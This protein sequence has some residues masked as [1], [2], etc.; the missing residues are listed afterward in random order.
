MQ[1]TCI[2]VIAMLT[3]AQ[4]MAA[5]HED[6]L[7]DVKFRDGL[8]IRL[9]DGGPVDVDGLALRGAVASQ[10]LAHLR[11]GG[12]TRTH[13]LGEEQLSALKRNGDQQSATPLPD[14]N[15]Y[16]RLRLPPGLSLAVAEAELRQLSEVESVHRVSLPLPPPAAPDLYTPTN[17]VWYQRYLDAAPD[18]VGIRGL[19]PADL[20]TEKICDVE[21]AWN[22]S[23][24][25]LPSGIPQVTPGASIPF[26]EPDLIFDTIQHGTSVLGIIGATAE[27][28]PTGIT[29]GAF[30][31]RLVTAGVHNGAMNVAQAITN[32]IGQGSTIIVVEQQFRNSLKGFVDYIPA[33]W[34]KPVHDAIRTAVA[35]GIVV[36]AVAGNGGANLDD[37][38][39]ETTEDLNK[40]FRG[41]GASGSILVGAGMSPYGG[42]VTRSPHA[43]S[44]YGSAIDVQGWGDSVVTL[45]WG[46]YYA[47]EGENLY[48]TFSADGTSA[49]APIVASAAAQLQARARAATGTALS[50]LIIKRLLKT[51]STP[52]AHGS[53]RPRNIGPLPNVA[54]AVSAISGGTRS[55]TLGDSIPYT[56]A[57]GR[58]TALNGTH[59][60]LNLSAGGH[61][62]FSLNYD[63]FVTSYPSVM[64]L[65]VQLV[66]DNVVVGTWL[67]QGSGRHAS[68]QVVALGPGAHTAWYQ[69]RSQLKSGPPTTGTIRGAPARF[70]AIPFAVNELREWQLTQD[71]IPYTGSTGA[72]TLVRDS[73]LEVDAPLGGL[74]GF[75]FAYS[76]FQ[77]P[78]PAAMRLEVRLM[79]DGV[80]QGRA[81]SSSNSAFTFGPTARLSP[82]THTVW[83]EVR[84]VLWSG[85]PATGTL[86]GT[87]GRVTARFISP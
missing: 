30:G 72:F 10:V 28:V 77:T 48:Y 31:A 47:A 66:V 40:P 68:A 37:A 17:F 13:A 39:Y 42:G 51:H 82:G 64:E 21:Y 44:T 18:G 43:Y 59:T 60:T 71:S 2:A 76:Y 16:F 56:G 19:A 8:S 35:N 73:H 11:A 45:G 5:N 12:W 75:E 87:P 3:A 9:R 53:G 83:F 1:Q 23:H 63:S 65:D 22:L 67:R 79:V 24:A 70:A 69:V 27:P 25:D 55:W 74:Y 49:A 86:G 14:L 84:S 33:E 62:R 7:L 15:L 32:C 85:P 57:D 26:T 78:S 80:E 54:A 36:V 52:Q 34:E 81:T 50:P 29:G 61:H 46:D 38:F 58:Y 41:Q 6:A 20:S 4:A